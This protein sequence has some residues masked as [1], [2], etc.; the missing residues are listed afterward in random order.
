MEAA[1]YQDLL[2]PL[3]TGRRVILAGGPVSPWTP[4]AALVRRLGATAVLVVGTEGRGVGPPPE[5]AEWIA[6]GKARP[7]MLAS[8]RA[9]TE[10]LRAPPAEVAAAVE[11]FD[12][13]RQALVI[14]SFLNEAPELC[15]RPFL[16]WR[17]PEWL[18]LE[19]KLV[20]DAVWDRSGV[21]R[22][23]SEIVPLAAPVVD[24]QEV[25]R[26]AR[27]RRWHGLG[28]RR[29]RRVAWRG[30]VAAVGTD[31]RRRRGRPR[32]AARPLPDRA[33]DAVPRGHPLQHPRHRASRRA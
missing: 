11:T 29:V 4:T 17:R 15:G 19:D 21:P 6:A 24:L 8:I 2:R 27:P 25:S 22:A 12:P 31:A 28:R 13:D 18:A 26:P 20:A 23:P 1:G 16:A 10:L 33:G 30:R 5:D 9:A 32:R 14:G 3:F 7:S